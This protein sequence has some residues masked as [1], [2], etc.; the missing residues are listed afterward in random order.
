[1]IV[2]AVMVGL[3]AVAMTEAIV[4]PSVVEVAQVRHQF[5]HLPL[6]QRPLQFRVQLRAQEAFLIL[7]HWNLRLNLTLSKQKLKRDSNHGQNGFR[8][9]K[10]PTM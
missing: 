3:L 10:P 4:G 6:H 9:P 2:I 7:V 5:L 1:V 8:R